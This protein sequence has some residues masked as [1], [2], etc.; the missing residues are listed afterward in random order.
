[1]FVPLHDDAPLRVIRFQVVNGLLILT[2]LIVFL[3]TNYG[4]TEPQAVALATSV[5]VVP[6]LITDHA[7]LDPSLYVVPEPATVLTY[8]FIHADWMHL[9]ANMLFLWVFG[10]N[11]ED[12]YGHWGFL[13]FFVVCGICAALTHTLFFPDS[14]MPLIGASGAVSGVLAAYLVLF[15]HSRVWILLFMRLPLRIAA[16]WV[17]LGWLGFQLLSLFLSDMSEEG[18][19]VAWWAHL[20]GFAA[21][22]VITWLFKNRLRERLFA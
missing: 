13:V 22:L 3:Y 21:G 18:V 4:L 20:G 17:L 15:P 11:V 14:Q 6:A 1:M 5:G 7:T 12:A 9:L 16:S 2:N 19:S 10:D 8:M